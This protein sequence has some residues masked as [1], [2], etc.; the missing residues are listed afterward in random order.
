MDILKI[1]GVWAHTRLWGTFHYTYF[2]FLLQLLYWCGHLQ[3]TANSFQLVFNTGEVGFEFVNFTL[4]HFFFLIG[5]AT[6]TSTSSFAI[7]SRGECH[8]TLTWFIMYYSLPPLLLLSW[9][10][11]FAFNFIQWCVSLNFFFFPSWLRFLFHFC[12]VFNI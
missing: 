4:Y 12:S 7:H 10:L 1:V 9:W 11:F 6:C 2:R 8:Q 5:H 3:F